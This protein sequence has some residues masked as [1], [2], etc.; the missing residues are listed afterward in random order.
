M[1]QITGT[2]QIINPLQKSNLNKKGLCDYVINVASGCHH[3]CKFCYVP[4]TP[5][6]RTRH[7]ELIERGVDDPQ[8]DWGKY[9]FIRNNIPETLKLILSSKKKWVETPSGKGVILMCSG[10]DPYQNREI[11]SLTNQTL[12]ILANHAK[13]IRILTRSP[14]WTQHLEILNNPNITIGMSLPHLD[15]SLSRRMEPHAPP[16]SARLKALKK[17]HQHGCR[18]YVAIAPTPPQMDYQ[19]FVEHLDK[20]MQFEPEVI[21]WEP[22]N[23]R[24]SNGK[25]MAAAGLDFVKDVMTRDAWADN[26][27]RQWH[28]IH[29]AAETVGCL[30]R[31]H[32]WVDAELKSYVDAED[33]EYWFYRPTVERWDQEPSKTVIRDKTDRHSEHNRLLH[34]ASA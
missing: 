5:A 23:A 19:D 29:K 31:L 24:G 26:F 21:F 14:L 4:S 30:D 3:G 6:I 1:S 13:R 18:T 27:L 28:D 10:T 17:G 32:I 2:E 9:L 11:A 16:P 22:I 33:L 15:D 7:H 8:L 34:S 20:V 12:T 25:R